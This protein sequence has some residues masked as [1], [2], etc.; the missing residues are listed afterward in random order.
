MFGCR[1][2]FLEELGVLHGKSSDNDQ[3]SPLEIP[4]ADGEGSGSVT[5]HS[6]PGCCVKVKHRGGLNICCNCFTISGPCFFASSQVSL[7][8]GSAKMWKLQSFDQSQ[9]AIGGASLGADL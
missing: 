8:L 3:S 2:P 4:G 6:D 9:P 7:H 1:S 5:T